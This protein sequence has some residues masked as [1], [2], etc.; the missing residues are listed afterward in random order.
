MDIR[1]GGGRIQVR[2]HGRTGR[3]YGGGFVVLGAETPVV[4]LL[5][6]VVRFRGGLDVHER[7]GGGH[8]AAAQRHLFFR[9]R[10][11]FNAL[12]ASIPVWQ[13]QVRRIYHE[14]VSIDNY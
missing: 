14:S 13:T 2:L 1:P 6:H 8:A 3:R 5:L 9:S 12:H 11:Y 10:Q 7:H 4:H